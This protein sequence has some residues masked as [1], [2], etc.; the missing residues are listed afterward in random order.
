M[1]CYSEMNEV[2]SEH[3]AG[4]LCKKFDLS[5]GVSS[6]FQTHRGKPSLV[7]RDDL[8]KDAYSKRDG[9][10]RAA[11]RNIALFLLHRPFSLDFCGHLFNC[12][13]FGPT[14]KR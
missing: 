2:P 11:I 12:K 7:I 8:L 9:F 10:T 3:L 5:E 1:W 14:E 4:M 13:I 6:E